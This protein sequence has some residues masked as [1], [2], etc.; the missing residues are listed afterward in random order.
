[1]AFS[2]EKEQEP[3]PAAQKKSGG[4]KQSAK[5]ATKPDQSVQKK[6]QGF[7]DK[8]GDGIDDRTIKTD[9]PVQS[10]EQNR[11]RERKRDHF[12]DTDG[13]GINDNRC[14]GLGFGNRNQGQK[15]RGG[16]K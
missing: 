2:Q 1:M 10:Q 13:D 3:T 6:L 9:E 4:D 16:Q 15:R 8:D 7:I 12:I 11:I 14:N 5:Q